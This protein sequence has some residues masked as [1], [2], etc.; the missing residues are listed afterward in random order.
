MAMRFLPELIKQMKGGFI[1]LGL[2]FLPELWMTLTGG[3]PKLFAAQRALF[4]PPYVQRLENDDDPADHRHAHQS[5]E[6]QARD[7]VALLAEAVRRMWTRL[8]ANGPGCPVP[9]TAGLLPVAD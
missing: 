6:D 9:T 7:D 5:D 3:V 2:K 1:S 8:D 4:V